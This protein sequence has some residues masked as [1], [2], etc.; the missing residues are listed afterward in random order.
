LRDYRR[1]AVWEKGHKL[2]LAVYASTATFPRDESFGLV[3][4]IRRAAISIPSNIAEG[5]GRSGDGELRRFLFIAMGSANELEYQLFLARDLNYIQGSDYDALSG[6][7]GEV[8]RML[9]G[10]I[11]RLRETA[12]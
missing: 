11:Q 10:L 12:N 2:V 5:C 7:L 4:Q 6:G 8:K 1:L 3:S 9:S